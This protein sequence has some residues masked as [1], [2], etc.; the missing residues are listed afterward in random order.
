MSFPHFRKQFP[1]RS[2]PFLRAFPLFSLCSYNG[3]HK[4]HNEHTS[5]LLTA[6]TRLRFLLWL[7][8]LPSAQYCTIF[9]EFLPYLTHQRVYTFFICD[10]PAFAPELCAIGSMPSFC[11]RTAQCRITIV[12]PVPNR[13]VQDFDCWKCLTLRLCTECIDTILFLWKAD[14]VIYVFVVYTILFHWKTG[15]VI[16]VL[17]TTLCSCD[18]ILYYSKILILEGGHWN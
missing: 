1:W 13:S 6:P 5:A 8:C 10:C 7:N 16:Y 3:V 9:C 11:H 2:P 18:K 15:S 12:K 4:M 17:V 14:N